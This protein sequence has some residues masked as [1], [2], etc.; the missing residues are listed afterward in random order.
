MLVDHVYYPP[1]GLSNIPALFGGYE[2]CPIRPSG[3]G[4]VGKIL[5]RH[6]FEIRRLAMI[7]VNAAKARPVFPLLT[8]V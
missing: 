2:I 7:Q 3:K 8:I 4:D 5:D 6:D 1:A